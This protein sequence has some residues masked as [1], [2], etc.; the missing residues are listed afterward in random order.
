MNFNQRYKL[1]TLSETHRCQRYLSIKFATSKHEI[2]HFYVI[3]A[4]KFES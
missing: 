1:A 3:N 4:G 2:D